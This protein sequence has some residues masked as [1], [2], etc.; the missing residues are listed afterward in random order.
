MGQMLIR[1]VGRVLT[2][3][4]LCTTLELTGVTEHFNLIALDH[5]LEL[6]FQIYFT[7][8]TSACRG[9]V[10]LRDFRQ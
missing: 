8:A 10:F 6:C 7:D 1:I 9:R 4:P 2:I 5:V 3:P